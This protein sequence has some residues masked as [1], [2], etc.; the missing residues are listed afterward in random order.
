M[1]LY[2]EKNQNMQND[3]QLVL[4]ETNQGKWQENTEFTR[5]NTKKQNQNKK[6]QQRRQKHNNNNNKNNGQ[7]QI[8][9]YL[10]PTTYYLL[11]TDILPNKS[12]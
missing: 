4:E 11:P 8:A 10:L 5:R 1:L 9:Y 3:S 12:L 6:I 7:V 2:I